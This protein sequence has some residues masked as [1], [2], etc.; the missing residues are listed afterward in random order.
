MP[1]SGS[2]RTA[3]TGPQSGAGRRVIF[4]IEGDGI[5]YASGDKKAVTQVWCLAAVDV[6]TEEEFYWGIDL[7]NVEDGVRFL[8]ECEVTVGHHAIGYDYPALEKLYAP[9]FNRPPKAWDSLVI[10]KCIWP[11]ETLITPDMH[12]INRGL[13]PGHLL[14][15]HSLKAWGYR[16]GTHK[17]EYSGGFDAWC[18]DMSEYL[19][20]DI[21]GTLALW[22]LIEDKLGWSE[23]AQAE[24]VLKWPELTIQTECDVARIIWEQEECGVSFDLEKA[25][26][27]AAELSNEKARIETLLVEAFGSWWEPQEDPEVGVVAAS[28]MNR[29]VVG[30]PDIT[31][32]RFSEKTGKELKPYVGPPLEEITEGSRYVHI[33]RVTWSRPNYVMRLLTSASALMRITRYLTV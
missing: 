28:T 9:I 21:R 25:Y 29:K 32:R 22:R 15:A 24:K 2:Y 17:G 6:D 7:R 11:P 10:A 14:K 12:R 27:L 13:M 18:E 20:G 30:S 26:K 1:G 5:L 16:T 3:L 4:D 19:M 23:K 33:K 31:I 8:S